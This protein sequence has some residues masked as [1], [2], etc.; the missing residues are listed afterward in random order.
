GKE[1]GIF[2]V[3]KEEFSFTLTAGNERAP[4]LQEFDKEFLVKMGDR[5]KFVT[6][7][8]DASRH[9]CMSNQIYAAGWM[10]TNS[11]CNSMAW[12]FYANAKRPRQVN[13]NGNGYSFEGSFMMFREKDP[14]T[15]TT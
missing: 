14:P 13:S 9:E 8:N 2:N 12:M 4:N 11:R 1:C 10:K 3:A 15:P 7:D 5:G 6:F